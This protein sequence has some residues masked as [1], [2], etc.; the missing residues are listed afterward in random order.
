MNGKTAKKHRRLARKI[1]LLHGL[2]L[3]TRYYGRTHRRL[4][5]AGLNPDGTPRME[6]LTLHQV[7]VSP[8][9]L[10]GIYHA[11]KRAVVFFK[12]AN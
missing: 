3:T 11:V 8:L 7:R 4:Y 1:A 5:Q 6:V 10:R 12:E 2:P 9:C